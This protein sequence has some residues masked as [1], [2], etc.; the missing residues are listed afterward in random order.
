MKESHRMQCTRVMMFLAVA[1]LFQGAAMAETIGHAF[2]VQV[3]G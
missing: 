1:A 3:K 2:D